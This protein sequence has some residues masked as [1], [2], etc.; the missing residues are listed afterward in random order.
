MTMNKQEI[1]DL[2]ARQ[3]KMRALEQPFYNDP[4]IYE[5]DLDRVFMQSWIYAGHISEIHNVG[6]WILFEFAGESVIII[7]SREGEVSALMNVCRHRGSRVCVEKHGYAKSLTCRYH[8]WTYDIDGSLRSAA[9]MDEGF[10]K[11]TMGLKEIH[12]EVLEGMIYVNFSGNPASFEPVRE[13]L[14]ECLRPYRLDKARVAF[15]QNYPINANWKLSLENYTECYHCAP[16][17][18]EYSRG[19]SLAKPEARSSDLHEAKLRST[20]FISN[21]KVLAPTMPMSVIRCGGGMSP[22]V[23]MVRR[24]HRCWVTSVITTA[25]PRI[26]R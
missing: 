21:Q 15:R 1:Q 19:H 11:S 2:L 16:A 24:S 20:E 9:Y 23:K 26:S 14:T 25:A 4:D 10:D 12:C 17:H 22:E 13:N 6:D 8:G 5:M 3:E 7:Q 18:P